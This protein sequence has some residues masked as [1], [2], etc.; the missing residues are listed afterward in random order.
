L[1]LLVKRRLLWSPAN[2]GPIIVARQVVTVHDI[3]VID[4]PEWFN[5]RFA[6]WYRWM[7]PR[8]IRRVSHVIAVSEFTKRR[9]VEFTGAEESRVS[10]VPNGVDKRFSPRPP[11]EVAAVHHRL[12]IPSS[13]Y[14]LSLAT[15]EPR[16][17]LAGQLEAWSRCVSQL[18]DNVWLVIAGG[19]GKGHVFGN[20]QLQNVPPRVHFTGYVR[21]EDLPALYSGAMTLLYPSFYEGFGLPVLEAMASGTAS[22]VSKSTAPHEVAGDAGIAVDPHDHDSIAAAIV[23][24]VHDDRRREELCQ[25]SV[26]RSETFS[27]ERAADSTWR[28]LEEAAQRNVRGSV[29]A[30]EQS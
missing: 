24:V 21:D 3:A 5:S 4:H 27:W 28:V 2:S 1:P 19:K 10:V 17:N 14:I 7:T 20:L 26:R 9:L 30:A 22:I 18:P 29:S 12:G 13:S 11:E 15:L 25:R 16:K 23:R 6:A 8:L